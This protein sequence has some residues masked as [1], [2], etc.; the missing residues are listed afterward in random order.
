[1]FGERLDV[2]ITPTAIAGTLKYR[3]LAGFLLGICSSEDARASC[4]TRPRTVSTRR[5]L[6]VEPY[7]QAGAPLVRAVPDQ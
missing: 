2:L 5:R 6:I 7:G 3:L 4:P 1:M